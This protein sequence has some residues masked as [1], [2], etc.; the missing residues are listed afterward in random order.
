MPPAEYPLWVWILFFSVVLA[1]LFVDIGLVNR[2]SHT[3]T[4][5]ETF[6]WSVVWVSLALAFNGFILYQ[7]GLLQ[8]KLFLTGYMIELSLSVDNLFVFLLIF[9]FFKVPREYQHRV[10]FWGIIGALVMRMVMIFAGAELVEHFHWVIYLFGAFLIYTGISMFRGGEGNFEPHESV[11]VKLLTKHVPVSKH[12]NGD[13]F[14]VREN[15]ML[16]GTLMLLV[17]VI[18]E[19]TDLVFAV[20]SIP[21]IFGITTDRFLVYTSNIFAILGL[22]TF[23]FLL[24]DLADRFHLLKVALAFVLT[25]I[26]VKMLLPLLAEGLIMFLGENATSGFSFFLR[27]FLNNEFEQIT[28]NVS[29]AV[30]VLAIALSIILSIIVPSKNSRRKNGADA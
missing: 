29:L 11:V 12:F 15:G 25:F 13:K 9:T 3:P 6:V 21:A 19:F 23:Y 1:A 30:V 28:I 5:K 22:R 26:G 20:D 17:L 7:F 27:R 18:V 10:L 24:A 4:R 8:A 16:A 2:R 14:F